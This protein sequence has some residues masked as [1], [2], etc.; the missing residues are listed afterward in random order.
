MK[1]RV[2]GNNHL[3]VS[4]IGLGCWGMSHT[5][6]RADEKESLATINH[7]L[8]HGIN[9]L[10]TADVYGNGHNESLIAKILKKRRH[11]AVVATK[12]GFVGDENGN[13]RVNGRPD[14]VFKA[15]EKSLMRLN[16]DE[17][18][19]YYFHR[20][21]PDVP[22]DETI[23]AM[24][25]LIHQGKVRYLGL[26]EVS[27]STLKKASAIHP[28][29]A[30]QSEYS[31]WQRDIEKTILPACRD[32]EISL[33][34]FSP[35]GRGFLTGTIKSPL[36]LKDND[37]RSNMPRFDSEA[38]EEN[39]KLITTLQE[40]AD[41]MEISLAQL[42][43]AWLLAQDDSI[44]PIPGMKQQ[45]Y[46]DENIKAV[47]MS[48]TKESLE[49]INTMEVLVKGRRHNQYNLDFIDE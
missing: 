7:C 21:D 44:V 38:M 11:E 6:G 3:T 45:K 8:D 43:L 32:L 26:S 28:I 5:Y 4:S 23:G 49:Q 46:I 36:D 16:I 40:L 35:L 19:L 47:G 1:N 14:Y 2:L 18:D 30:L 22:I 39:L 13:V 20:L 10:D 17:I 42:S 41:E 29:T 9:F 37:Y 48:F 15:C 33:I 12:F 31:L 27:A 25:D 24:A 34:P